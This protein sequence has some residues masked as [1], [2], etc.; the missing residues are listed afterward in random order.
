L[1]PAITTTRTGGFCLAV[2]C[3]A[4]LS[5]CSSGH[6]ADV[7]GV[8]IVDEE[9]T[10][11]RK[12]RT[13][14][15]HR[16]YRVEADATYVAMVEEDGPEVTVRLTHESARGI[17]AETIEVDS[18]LVG[19]GIE[20][21]VLAVPRGAHLAISIESAPEFEQPGAVR[22]K[23]FRYSSETASYPEVQARLAAIRA[24]SRGTNAKVSSESGDEIRDID[25]AL[26]QFESSDGSP[27]LAAWGRMVRSRINYRKSVD[28][29]SALFDAQNAVRRFAALGATRNAGRA[30]LAEAVVLVELA[31]DAGARNPTR[32]EAAHQAKDLLISLS[33]DKSLS[34]TE[35]ARA[36]NNQGVL[37]HNLYDW[38]GAR[39]KWQE[40]IPMYEAIGDRRGRVQ[41]LQNL[42]V[43]ASEEGDYRT[44]RQY[45]DRVLA[46][47]DQVGS[48]G[49]RASMLL[50]AAN[51]EINAGHIDP[52]IEHLLRAL[53]L[54][55][56]HKMSLNEPRALHGLGR[57]YQAR[58]DSA[59]ATTF[60]AAALKLYRST[61]DSIGL[62][63][64]LVANGGLARDARDFAQAVALHTE[65]D[66][67]AT[68]AN[69]HLYARLEL[70][71]DYVA[72]LDFERA[73]AT[74]RQI[75][76]MPDLDPKF[77]RLDE[78]RLTLAESL[79]AQPRRTSQAVSEATALTQIALNAGI[80][81]EDTTIELG[82]R[83][84]LA[85]SH[86]VRGEIDKAREEYQRA[87]ALVFKYRSNLNSPELQAATAAQ[88]QQ[89]FRGYVDLLMRDAVARGPDMLSPVSASEEEALRVLEWARANNFDPARISQLDAVAQERVDEL[90]TGM[91]GKRVRMAALLESSDDVTRQLEI[92]QL[93]IAQLRAQVDRLRAASART[94]SATHILPSVDA[95]WPAIG[96]GVTQLSYMLDTGHAY[97]W[98]RD[99]SGIRSTVLAARPAGVARDLSAL[100]T[101]IRSR[102]PQQVD[103]TLARL[104]AV[105][106][107]P[108]AIAADSTM[109]QIVADGKIDSIPFAGLS[110]PRSTSRLT[111]R[112]SVVMIT[113]LFEPR[114]PPAFREDRTVDL[115]AL[116]SDARSIAD[117]PEAAVF[118]TLQNTNSEVRA[119]AALFRTSNPQ[120]TIKLLSGA[121]GS[122]DNLEKYWHAGVD[123]IHFATHGLP[124]L[125]QP[126]TSLLLLPARDAAGKAAYLTAGQVMEWHGDVDLVFLGACDT[127][128]GPVRFAEGMSGLQGAFLRAGAR[129]VIGT[130][131]P[132]EDVY[133]SQ[134]AADF[135]RRYTAG[136]SAA[137]SLSET[138]RAWL[139]PSPGIRGSEQA[140]RRMTASAHVFYA[141]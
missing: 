7:D 13:D 96:E 61:Q 4:F 108:D 2:L 18:K 117:L 63:T 104:S 91:A 56:K 102:T 98:A 5:A 87:I 129:G 17:A 139:E 109:I 48:P 141:R 81:R 80:L 26:A 122:A 10:L 12:A 115:V 66:S 32:E 137:E 92:L 68:A 118:S 24:W 116:S 34:A 11:E 15:A 19:S 121:D 133:A 107:P 60:H 71:K 90:L 140:Y 39:S 67:V 138:Q 40:V 8:L 105:L 76:A 25:L 6:R 128:V 16:E 85:Q 52:A 130:L 21:A 112:Q 77:Y 84:L 22:L 114:T 88:E 42:G 111:D 54:A 94:A 106:I 9:V 86:V 127:A 53:D 126:L 28:L 136:K 38:P 43:L 64:S 1:D 45:F 134:F 20:L 50:N 65:A 78:V 123:V 79:L 95:A 58:G 124:D 23:I 120:S 72:A 36:V 51:A 33:S 103:A 46:S 35:R 49:R 62:I 101:A 131:W 132:V 119:I 125:R 31:T 69:S 97:L 70:A 73:I 113:S 41:S 29:K 59:Q 37:A 110:W 75:I 27:V 99:S 57:A 82:G 3:A 135:Y 47:L 74:C 44:A 89:I 30:Q 100:A 83:R 14:I 93:D 55:R